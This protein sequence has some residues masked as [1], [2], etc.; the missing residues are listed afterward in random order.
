[1]DG[2]AASSEVSSILFPGRGTGGIVSPSPEK[3][4]QLSQ[5]DA[6]IQARRNLFDAGGRHSKI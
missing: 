3:V 5:V 6:G 1:M 2:G 4:K